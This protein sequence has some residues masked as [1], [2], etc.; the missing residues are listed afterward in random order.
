MLLYVVYG[1][2]GLAA[3]LALLAF[4]LVFSALMPNPVDWL[5]IRRVIDKRYDLAAT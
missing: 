5:R 3:T 4:G 2:L 1:V